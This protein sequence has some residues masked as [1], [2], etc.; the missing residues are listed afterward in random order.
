MLT[1]YG[2]S[3]ICVFNLSSMASRSLDNNL[4]VRVDINFVPWLKEN[5]YMFLKDRDMSISN[6]LEGMLNSFENSFM[7]SS[8]LS[9]F[10]NRRT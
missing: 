7:I 4:N 5:L 6:S 1:S 8:S 9:I 2:I 3:G 10:L